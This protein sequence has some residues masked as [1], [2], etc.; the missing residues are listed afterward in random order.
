MTALATRAEVN[1]VQG[2]LDAAE[3]DLQKVLAEA[4]GNVLGM[5][6]SARLYE[7]RGNY[8]AALD[9]A[10][11]IESRRDA[12]PPEMLAEFRAFQAELKKRDGERK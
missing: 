2:N 12:M 7:R 6:L 3:T 5:F 4:P 8:A 9:L 1:L 11:T 10:S